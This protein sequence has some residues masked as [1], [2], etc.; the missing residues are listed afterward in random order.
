MNAEKAQTDVNRNVLILWEV[1][2]VHVDLDIVCK[3][4]DLGVLVS[5][6]FLIVVLFYCAVV[7]IIVIPVNCRY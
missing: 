6:I 1:M 7:Y 5:T 4:M 3:V 2:N